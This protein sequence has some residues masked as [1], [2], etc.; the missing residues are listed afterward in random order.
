[1]FLITYFKLNS[2]IDYLFSI[3][4]EELSILIKLLVKSS[5]CSFYNIV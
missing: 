2:I 5:F 4:K 1:M 3:N